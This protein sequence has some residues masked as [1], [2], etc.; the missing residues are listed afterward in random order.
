[1]K[2]GLVNGIKVLVIGGS[3]FVGRQ[4]MRYFSCQGTSGSGEEGFI[5]LDLMDAASIRRVI[6]NTSPDLVINSAGITNVDYCES[7]PDE[8]M[9]INGTAVG[10][11]ADIVEES[12]STLCQIS[13]DYVFSGQKGNYAEDDEAVPVNAYGKSKLAAEDELRGRKCM[14][15]RISTPYGINLA[16]KKLTFMDFVFSSLRSGKQVRIVTDQFTTPT[17]VNDIP[18]A[19]E[20]MYRSR[21]MGTYNL[22]SRECTSRYDFSVILAETFTLD[23]NLIL[24]IRT[25]ELGLLAKRP[26]NT[27][28]DTS[29]IG[30]FIRVESIRKNLAEI[31]KNLSP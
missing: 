22:G 3:G 1:M 6:K 18:I 24:P 30:K 11:L 29:K 10:S 5:K 4:L 26:L 28:M 21:L 15:L 17:Y 13:T 31:R 19:I 7:H 16:G 23:K 2:N 20:A 9:A 12:G 8:A 27:C 14:I 25:N